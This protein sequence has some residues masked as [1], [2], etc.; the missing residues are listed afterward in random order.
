MV[1]KTALYVRDFFFKDHFSTEEAYKAHISK[2]DV[3]KT[4][5]YLTKLG[6][7]K[8]KMP[9]DDALVVMGFSTTQ[10]LLKTY[11]MHRWVGIFCVAVSVYCVLFFFY[12]LGGA[13]QSSLPSSAVIVR[14]I[15]CLGGAAAM[16][17][18]GGNYLQ[19]VWQMKNMKT[20]NARDWLAAIKKNGFSEAFPRAMPIEQAEALVKRTDALRKKVNKK[21][22]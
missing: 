21:A 7:N 20:G 12:L 22:A 4:K 3:E 2:K 16:L 11:N 5:E 19:R 17:S 10:Q 9:F 18:I 8:S 14:L 13:S 6:A 15:S 1:K